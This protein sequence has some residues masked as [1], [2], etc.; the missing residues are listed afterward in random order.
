MKSGLKCESNE[1]LHGDKNGGKIKHVFKKTLY[2]K[3]V[4][5]SP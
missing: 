4:K 3:N 5:I 1:V 2:E